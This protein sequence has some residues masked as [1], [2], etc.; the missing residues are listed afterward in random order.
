MTTFFPF[1]IYFKLLTK[2]A[3]PFKILPLIAILK[4]MFLKIY[5]TASPAR[6]CKA[7]GVHHLQMKQ[8]RPFSGHDP[9][10]SFGFNSSKFSAIFPSKVDEEEAEGFVA[11][12]FPSFICKWTASSFHLHLQAALF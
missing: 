2:I 10:I 1:R 4:L 11:G 3:V 6:S 9:D 8:M 12:K 5:M 7:T